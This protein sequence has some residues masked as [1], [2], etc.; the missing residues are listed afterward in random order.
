[1]LEVA[2]IAAA[3]VAASDLGFQIG[4]RVN[5]AGRLGDAMQ[6]VRL[7][8]SNG[9]EAARALAAALDAENA[10]RRDLEKQIVAEA[11]AQV[12]RSPALRDARGIVVGDERWHPGVVGIV[13][14]RLVDRFG[15]PA[16]VF[17][18]GGRGSARSVEKLHL[19]DA[20]TRVRG[21]VGD[22]IVGFGGH[23]HAAGVRLRSGALDRFRDAFLAEAFRAL[24]P[25]DLRRVAPYDGVLGA[26]VVDGD[27]VQRLEQAAPFGRSNPEPVFLFPGVRLRS[28]RL[29]GAAHLKGVVD[30]A[31]L[32]GDRRAR[33]DVIAFGAAE[34]EAEWSGPVDLLATPEI[35]EFRGTRTVQLRV[36]DFRGSGAPAGAR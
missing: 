14:S 3:Q 35:N 29:V 34:R 5:A 22:D 12:E 17:G 30:P 32:G 7:L 31:D 9:G 13:A 11:I 36:K 1:L 15:R 33:L 4:P 28:V 6:G 24:Q 19:H 23:H 18:E 21:V 2:D 20:L 26:G 25:D 27:F 8:R 10:A 16:V